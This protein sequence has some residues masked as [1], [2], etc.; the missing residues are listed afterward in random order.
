MGQVEEPRAI[1]QEDS[2]VRAQIGTET[3]L[4]QL[5][6]R[7]K[8]GRYSKKK[9]KK[10]HR[11]GRNRRRKLGFLSEED[12]ADESG[13]EGNVPEVAGAAACAAAAEDG[14]D[15][16]GLRGGGGRI[17]GRRSRTPGRRQPRG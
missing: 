4:G 8:K 6:I 12:F 16:G 14:P 17:G 11:G 7:I 13:T 2:G 3:M 5:G 10:G 1:A 9:G 15:P